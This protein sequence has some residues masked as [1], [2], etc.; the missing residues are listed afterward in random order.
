MSMKL[1]EQ[2]N[3]IASE[4]VGSHYD[5][6]IRTARKMGVVED[7]LHDIVADVYLS[8]VRSENNG[9]GY[10]SDMGR[11]T[12]C[13]S[14]S[15]F[16]YGRMKLYSKNPKYCTENPNKYEVSASSDEDTD[17]DVTPLTAAQLAYASAASYDDEDIASIDAAL[18][19]S[20]E[21]EYILQ[22]STAS[23]VQ[24]KYL[25]KNIREFATM[26]FDISVMSDVKRL[27]K[28]FDFAEAFRS[29][30]TFANNDP[31]SYD[32]LVSSL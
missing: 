8:I 15:E 13:I 7:K 27:L 12:D 25:L 16:V 24:L 23:G 1:M 19:V 30:L 5:E 10:S 21:I 14:I 6:M 20:E 26:D 9:V 4:F 3:T 11:H 29:V 31:T 17:S 18:S 28:D 32:A 22:F 2:K